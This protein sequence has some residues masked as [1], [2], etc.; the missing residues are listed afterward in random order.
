VFEISGRVNLDCRGELLRMVYM[1][2][3]L[4]RIFFIQFK[5]NNKAFLQ[6][7]LENSDFSTVNSQTEEKYIIKLFNFQ[8]LIN[9]IIFL[10][11]IKL[12]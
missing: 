4:H 6:D 2:L 7:K 5:I 9:Y 10:I 11:I 12:Y 8:F 1:N 3:I